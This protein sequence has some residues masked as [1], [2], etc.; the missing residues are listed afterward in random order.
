MRFLRTFS[1]FYSFLLI[2]VSAQG[3]LSIQGSILDSESNE[4]I[5]YVN[6]GVIGKKV[7]TVSRSDGSFTLDI[8]EQHYS[9]PIRISI[10]GYESIEMESNQLEK[11]LRKDPVIKLAPTATEIEEVV[12]SSSKLKSKEVGNLRYRKTMHASFQ[13]DTLGKEMGILIKIKKRPTII[14]EFSFP[15]LNELGKV[16]FRLN[17]YEMENGKPGRNVLKDNIIIETEVEEGLVTTDLS[18]YNITVEDDFLITLE[19]IEEYEEDKLHFGATIF[20]K[21]VWV[22]STSQSNWFKVPLIG[23][24]I[25]ATILY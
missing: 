16:K 18:Q 2:A 25:K 13:S 5:S 22:R 11:L 23:I 24:G 1:F 15:I 10:I 8:P 21:P 20:S 14:K 19:W 3:Q 6:I 4:P 9:D 17:I 7:G 12:I